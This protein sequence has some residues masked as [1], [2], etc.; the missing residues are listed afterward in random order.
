MKNNSFFSNIFKSKPN[1]VGISSKILTSKVYEHPG[2]DKKSDQNW[3]KTRSISKIKKVLRI[4]KKT[5]SFSNIFK[6]KPNRVGISSKVLTSKVYENP[7]FDKKSDQNWKTIRSFSKIFKSEPNQVGI[8]SKIL[9]SKVYEHPGFDKKVLRIENK[10]VVFLT[11]SYLNQIKL[12]FRVK[13]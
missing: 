5:S 1:Q 3:K 12:E 8:S 2:F 9:T 6:S 10:L 4:G 7:G 11:F 13:F